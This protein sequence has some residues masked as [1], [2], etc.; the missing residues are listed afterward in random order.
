M[1]VIRI[2]LIHTVGTY[3]LNSKLNRDFPMQINSILKLTIPREHVTKHC[4]ITTPQIH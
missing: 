1:S 4:L 3:I 2:I